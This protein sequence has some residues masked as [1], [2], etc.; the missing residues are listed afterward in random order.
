MLI[1]DINIPELSLSNLNLIHYTQELNI[2]NFRGVFM[3]NTLPKKPYRK[4]CGRVN[5]N[6]SAEK[7]SHWVAYWKSGNKRTHILIPLDKLRR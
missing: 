4:E 6:T 1:Y 7:G 2:P 3:S 5:L